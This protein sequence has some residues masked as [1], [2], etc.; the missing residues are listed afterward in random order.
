METFPVNV[1]VTAL[2]AGCVGSYL[3][4]YSCYDKVKKQLQAKKLVDIL[5]FKRTKYSLNEINKVLAL[6][7]LTLFALSFTPNMV[8]SFMTYGMEKTRE[9]ATF[10]LTL[11]GC[12]SCY[13]MFDRYFG[14]K[15]ISMLLGTCSVTSLWLMKLGY[16]EQKYALFTL[17]LSTAHFYTM[18][19]TPN[20]LKIRPF[21]FNALIASLV[22]IGAVLIK[23]Y[24]EGTLAI[25]S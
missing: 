15:Q 21:G 14:N 16:I 17:M 1:S 24:Q 8:S 20:G 4:L 5:S 7:G 10:L 13:A 18:E 12:Y 22:T 23:K 9:N 19:S 3:V 11:H 25:S 2:T 6:S